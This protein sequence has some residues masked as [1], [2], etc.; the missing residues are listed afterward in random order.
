MKRAFP[1]QSLLEL[2]QLHLDE[3]GRRLGE[4]IAGEA[5]AS[6]RHDMLVEYREEYR[7]RFLT[8]AQSGLRPGEWQNYTRFLARLDEAI[9]QA[10]AAMALS[11]RQTAAGQRDWVDKHGRVKA[12]DTLSDR[13]R[14]RVAYHDQRQ[15]QKAADE[16]AA[17]RHE[18]KDKE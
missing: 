15:E 8:A 11:R 12:F 1:L 13:H 5:E 10:E 7:A 4:L 16:H 2:S 14:A 18:E 17:R 9:G 6:R 3:A